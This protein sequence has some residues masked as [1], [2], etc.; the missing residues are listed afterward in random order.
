RQPRESSKISPRQTAGWGAS[1]TRPLLCRE[2]V[3]ENRANQSRLSGAEYGRDAEGAV[4]QL[5]TMSLAESVIHGA[6]R[7]RGCDQFRCAQKCASVDLH[8]LALHCIRLR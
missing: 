4:A 6:A 8:A 3:R 5:R 7:S 2:V 1:H